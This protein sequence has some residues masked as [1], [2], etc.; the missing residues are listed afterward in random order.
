MDGQ[1][2]TEIFAYLDSFD[3]FAD[4]QK[5]GIS[6][7]MLLDGHQLHFDVNFLCYVNNDVSKWSICIGVPY[8][9]AYWQVGDSSEQNDKF[10]MRLTKEKKKLF[11]KE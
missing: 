2:L 10:K 11:K 5:N 7:F 6:P 8:V 1:T 9:T 4:D 3:L